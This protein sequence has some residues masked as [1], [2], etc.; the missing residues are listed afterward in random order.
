MKYK[1]SKITEGYIYRGYKIERF[2]AIGTGV[3]SRSTLWNVLFE[4]FDRLK[5]AKC[6]I[7]QQDLKAKNDL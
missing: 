5:D 3:S 7:D 1:A 4:T 6:F 2:E